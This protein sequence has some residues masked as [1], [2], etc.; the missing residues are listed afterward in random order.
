MNWT[1]TMHSKE[2]TDYD[3]FVHEAKTTTFECP[4]E[5]RQTVYY[6]YPLERMF[7]KTRWVVRKTNISSVWASNI[8][9][10]RLD[11]GDYIH[12][13]LFYRL[14][15]DKESA[16]DFCTKKNQQLKVKIYGDC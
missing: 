4:F 14:F 5:F 1:I 6:A 7:R 8:F 16:I 12:E 15:T 9:G 2:R 10:V 13:D 3:G 11:C